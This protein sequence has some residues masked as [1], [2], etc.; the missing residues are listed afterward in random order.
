MCLLRYMAFVSQQGTGMQSM[1]SD[2][3]WGIK[4]TEFVSLQVVLWHIT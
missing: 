1:Q 4:G 3:G 2:T